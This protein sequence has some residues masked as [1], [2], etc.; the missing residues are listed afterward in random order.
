MRK[1]LKRLGIII[2]LIQES[3]GCPENCS[4][5]RESGL[6]ERCDYGFG[7]IKG[8]CERCLVKDCKYCDGDTSSC[9]TCAIYHFREESKEI[10]GA[11]ECQ[12]CG[13]GCMSCKN[14]EKCIKC[15]K[16]F[17]FSGSNPNN[18]IADHR[19]LFFI[20][21]LILVFLLVTIAL[22]FYCTSLTPEEEK[23]MIEKYLEKERERDEP[24]NSPIDTE[25]VELQGNL[26]TREVKKGKETRKSND[27]NYSYDDSADNKFDSN[28]RRFWVG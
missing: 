22:G 4:S 21:V 8:N 25:G 15:G 11:F 6:C 20:M 23:K 12:K 26:D 18:C 13:F 27:Q 9:E 24:E 5:C 19:T 7:L 28:G 17:K 1:T 16:M 14:E 3:I 2:W 10:R